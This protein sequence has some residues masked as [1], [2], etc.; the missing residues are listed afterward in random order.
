MLCYAM[1]CYIDF[2]EF[3]SVNE[4]DL[5]NFNFDTTPT[6]YKRR[7]SF[8]IPLVP[9]DEEELLI[10]GLIKPKIRNKNFFSMAEISQWIQKSHCFNR[11][12]PTNTDKVVKGKTL[13]VLGMPLFLPSFCCCCSKTV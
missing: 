11:V 4:L 7:K 1:L 12:L 5:A 10:Q 8:F 6:K 3:S 2:R 9:L 13:L